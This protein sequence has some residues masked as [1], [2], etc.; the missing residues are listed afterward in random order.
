MSCPK[1][2]YTFSLRGEPCAELF[3]SCVVSWSG[4]GQSTQC[5]TEAEGVQA[6]VAGVRLLRKDLQTANGNALKAKILLQRLQFQQAAVAR[7]SERLSTPHPRKT[8]Q[9]DACGQ[10]PLAA[11]ARRTHHRRFQSIHHRRG[12]VSS[13][14]PRSRRPRQLEPENSH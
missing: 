13:R 7:V 6:L 4:L 10:S 9:H 2:G 11:R 5:P 8:L 14:P 12:H 3:S 1:T